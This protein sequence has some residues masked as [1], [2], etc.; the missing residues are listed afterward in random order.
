MI[1]YPLLRNLTNVPDILERKP[2]DGRKMRHSTGPLAFFLSVQNCVTKTYE[3]KPVA[4][5]MD[6]LACKDD[7]ML[8]N[9]DE[10]FPC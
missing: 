1:E 5:Q 9:F 2:K 7:H 4:I 8:N 10:N 6:F 3:L